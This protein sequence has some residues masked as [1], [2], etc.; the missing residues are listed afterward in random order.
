MVEFGAEPRAVCGVFAV[1]KP[2][3]AQRF[4]VDARPANWHFGPPVAV[5]LPT[6]DKLAAIRMP[7]GPVYAA[8]TDLSDF[9]HTLSTPRWLRP[10]FALPPVRAGAV[11]PSVGERFGDASMVHPMCTT[12]PMGFSHSVLLA[13]EAH[14]ALLDSMP[15]LFDR[16]D[17]IG[18]PLCV[19]LTLRPGRVFHCCYIDDI[20]WL[21][22]DQFEIARRQHTYIAAAAKV[23]WAVKPSKV[24]APA[25]QGVTILGLLFDGVNR[26]LRLAPDKAVALIRATRAVVASSRPVALHHFARLMGLWVWAMLPCRPALAIF[27]SAFAFTRACLPGGSLLWPSARRELLAAAALLPL[28]AADLAAPFF[29]KLLASDASEFGAGVVSALIPSPE[30]LALTLPGLPPAPSVVWPNPLR[31]VRCQRVSDLQW[32]TIVSSKW[33]WSEHINSLELRA[34]HLSVRWVLRHS[35]AIGRRVLLLTDSSVVRGVVRKGRSSSVALLRR[36]RALAADVMAG[37]L[38][39]DIAWLPS[40]LNPADGPSRHYE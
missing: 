8:K 4:I 22:L 38:S 17:R 3:D 10:F 16:R 20:A 21:G 28:F 7:F 12:L 35:N 23:G 2:P 9:Y 5:S 1:L 26:T 31:G 24:V 37:A 13:Q 40:A 6:P 32:A 39:L 29:P 33:R 30:R 27:G 18:D 14:E 36:M 25:V 34:C 11:S 19:D 15:D